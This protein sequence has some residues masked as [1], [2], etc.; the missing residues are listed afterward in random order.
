MDADKVVLQDMLKS[1]FGSDFM[2]LLNDKE[3]IEIMVNA[4]P[5]KRD[6][7][8]WVER[9]D[10]KMEICFRR[11]NSDVM[12]IISL[13]ASSVKAEV[14]KK[15]P[16][17]GA[18]LIFDGSRVKAL[19]PPLSS[20]PCICIRKKP[21]RIYTLQEQQEYGTI[22][23]RQ[24]EILIQKVNERVNIVIAGGTSSGKTTFANSL[25]DVLKYTEERIIIIEERVELQCFAPNVVQLRG[26]KNY[27]IEQLLVDTLEL[28]PDRIIV[29]EVKNREALTLIDAW[30]TGHPGGFATVHAN[31]AILTLK[32]LEQLVQR[33]VQSP[34]KEAIAEAVKVIV[35]LARDQGRKI[36]VKEIVEVQGYDSQKDVY[37]FKTIK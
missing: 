16:S 27:S 15:N 33:V 22:T 1:A 24:K 25:L 23:E 12:N 4:D 17:V 5:I 28:R 13:I 10:G 7:V 18:E 2:E 30:N 36:R 8:I 20:G 21:S 31:S 19:I 11:S 35:F 34:Q 9:A 37:Q 14:N 3:I 6:T 29:G 26:N 32:R